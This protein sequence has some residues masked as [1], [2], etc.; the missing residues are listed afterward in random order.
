M[1]TVQVMHDKDNE[2]FYADIQGQ[3]AELTYKVPEDG[4]IDFKRTFVPENLRGNDIGKQI[5]TA[6]LD[7]A[8]QNNYRIIT[9][10]RFV[11]RYLHS[12]HR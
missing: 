6:G 4:L 11:E 5:V 8:K 10:C 7:Y 12:Q 3:R 9:T 1:T 2:V